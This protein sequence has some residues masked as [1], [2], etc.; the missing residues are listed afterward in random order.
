MMNLYYK[1]F[2]YSELSCFILFWNLGC[3]NRSLDLRS[4]QGSTPARRTEGPCGAL[5]RREIKGG[6]STCKVILLDL[7]CIYTIINFAYIFQTF[8]TRKASTWLALLVYFTFIL[9]YKGFFLFFP[10]GL[11]PL[12]LSGP[13]LSL[14]H[15]IL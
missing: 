3:R 1:A 15:L 10:C 9:P 6:F 2:E 14:G 4:R 8:P 7:Y 11:F 12:W 13:C 5:E